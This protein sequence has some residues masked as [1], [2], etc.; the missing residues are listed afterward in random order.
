ME[1][2]FLSYWATM[3]CRKQAFSGAVLSLSTRYETANTQTPDSQ[4]SDGCVVC[5]SRH[6]ADCFLYLRVEQ[7]SWKCYKAF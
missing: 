2:S 7:L 5:D 6:L 3:T 4:H 1:M